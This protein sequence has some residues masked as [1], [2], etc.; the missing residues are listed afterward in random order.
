MWKIFNIRGY[1]VEVINKIERLK[2][3]KKEEEADKERC[4]KKMKMR[5]DPKLG[6]LYLSMAKS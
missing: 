2:E 4:V 5:K 3:D 6:K 1:M